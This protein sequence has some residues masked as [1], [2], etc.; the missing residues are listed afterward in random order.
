MSDTLSF[1]ELEGQYVEQLPTRTVMSLFTA[2]GDAGTPGA[3]GQGEPGSGHNESNI[4]TGNRL[5]MESMGVPGLS[6]SASPRL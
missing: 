4:S 2:N 1:A 6:G 5:D 3:G